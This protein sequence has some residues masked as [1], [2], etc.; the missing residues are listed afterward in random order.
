MVKAMGADNQSVA[1]A[2]FCRDTNLCSKS[3]RLKSRILCS[4]TDLVENR[5]VRLPRFDFTIK[6]YCR[7]AKFESIL[8]QARS[9]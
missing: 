9:R 3:E 7:N 4:K 6:I 2:R 8:G 5:S 1:F